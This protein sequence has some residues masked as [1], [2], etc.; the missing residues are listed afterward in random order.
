MRS[1]TE[2]VVQDIENLIEEH[3]VASGN[4]YIWA[5][6]APNAEETKMHLENMEEHK[7]L[8]EMYSKMLAH[9][10]TLIEQFGGM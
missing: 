2:Q 1:V 5:L 4:E 10:P 8:V 7:D 9:V 3:K 6:G